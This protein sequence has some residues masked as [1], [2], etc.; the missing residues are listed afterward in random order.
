MLNGKMPPKMYSVLFL[1]A[2]SSFVSPRRWG[3][4]EDIGHRTGQKELV[5]LVPSL[6]GFVE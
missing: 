2:E 1:R 3:D 5:G 6:L 4:T